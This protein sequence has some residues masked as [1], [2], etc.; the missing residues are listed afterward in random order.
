MNIEYTQ[1]NGFV[2]NLTHTPINSTHL[3]TQHTYH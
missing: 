3:L 2:S 1:N